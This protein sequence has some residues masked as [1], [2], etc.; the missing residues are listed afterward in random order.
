M[1]FFV[2]ILQ[3]ESTSRYYCGYTED[4]KR[5]LKQHNDSNYKGS[6]TTKVFKGPWK[7]IWKQD[8]QTRSHAMQFERKIKKR[9]IQRFLESNSLAESR[10]M[11][12]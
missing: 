10:N 5:R 11:R 1:P 7:L 2:Y 3:S 9:G 8:I 6:R 12:D 4:L